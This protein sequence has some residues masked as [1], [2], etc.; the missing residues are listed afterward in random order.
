MTRGPD[1]YALGQPRGLG[2]GGRWGRFKREGTHV[3]LCLIDIVIRQ[4]P[5]QH[6]K[7]I[8]LQL[9]INKKIFKS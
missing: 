1:P 7:A 8:I 4:K 2:W 3:C 9:K 6:C 5:A